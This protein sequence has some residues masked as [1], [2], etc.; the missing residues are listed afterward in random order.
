MH[1]KIKIITKILGNSFKSNDEV[2]FFCPYCKHEKR[3][4]S[5]N[6]A[7][8]VFKCW[9]C[10]T[11][12]RDIRR[13]VRRYGDYKQLQRWDELSNTVDINK[14]DRVLFGKDEVKQQEQKIRLPEEFESLAN[15][16]TPFTA[17]SALKYLTKRDISKRDILHWKIGYCV[18]GAYAGRIVIP[19]FNEEGYVNYFVARSYNKSPKRYKNP[20]VSRDICFNELYIDWDDDLVITE[21][22]F[23]AIQ[24]GPNAIPLLGSTLRENSKLFHKIVKNDTP[25]YLALDADAEKKEAKIINLL[26]KYGIETYKVDTTG[27]EDVGVM[28]KERFKERKENATFITQGDYLL[29]KALMQI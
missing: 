4:M 19:S 10:D 8:N 17:L 24:A 18:K 25:V 26:L 27:Y 2:L 22:I 5:I 6:F 21:G 20:P 15:G 14:F 1:E 28:T 11:T 9:V 23:D 12:G 13:I 7:K 3:K 16:S 29:K